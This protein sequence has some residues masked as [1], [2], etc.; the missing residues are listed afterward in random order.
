MSNEIALFVA[1]HLESL[2]TKGDPSA[3]KSAK[4][5]MVR[6]LYKRGLSAERVRRL[7]RLIDG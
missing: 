1:A 5:R 2:R 4:T 3:R 7:F 6:E